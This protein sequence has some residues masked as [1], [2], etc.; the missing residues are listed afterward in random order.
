MT[1]EKFKHRLRRLKRHCLILI[2]KFFNSGHYDRKVKKPKNMTES[3]IQAVRIWAK[4]IHNKDSELMYNPKTHDA[5]AVW[6]S[7]N[8][9]IYLFLEKE[10]LRIINTVVGYDVKLSVRVDHWCLWMFSREVDKRRTKFKLDA[11]SKVIHSLDSLE[12]R[13]N[14]P[15]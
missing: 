1:K 7:P 6:E 14:L 10:N 2:N 9:V 13:L 3:E 4:V 8:G 5:Y 11:E 12:S 15:N